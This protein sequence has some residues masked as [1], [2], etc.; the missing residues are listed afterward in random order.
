MSSS[1]EPR[2]SAKCTIWTSQGPLKVELWAKQCPKVA[3]RFLK[4]CVND[5]YNGVSFERKVYDAA[6]QTSEID[7]EP[8]GVLESDSRIK[9]NRRGLLAINLESKGDFFITLRETPELDG[10][11][12]VLG[13]LVDNTFYTL[14]DIAGKEL[15]SEKKDGRFLYPAIVDRIEVEEQFFTEDM[16]METKK[17]ETSVTSQGSRKRARKS[18]KVRLDYDDE[19][20]HNET[21]NVKITSAHDLLVPKGLMRSAKNAQ[22]DVKHEVQQAKEIRDG[23]DINNDDPSEKARKHHENKRVDQNVTKTNTSSKS[24]RTH[25][26]QTE[27]SPNPTSEPERRE[28]ETM[29]LLAKF[30][31]KLA[32]A[33]ALN[34]H[35]L[36]FGDKKP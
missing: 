34:S 23:P 36:N 16:K 32:K 25:N 4:N 24:A 7:N 33:S 14:L 31:Q 10:Q 27:G 11:V 6:V 5:R 35:E 1:L 18:A 13:Q 2:T 28:M 30:K 20:E 15:D 22:G 12:T 29:E 3:L 26:Q 21:V 9:M 17:R 19:D 8:W